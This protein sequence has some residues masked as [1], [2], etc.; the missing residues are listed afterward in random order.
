[1]DSWFFDDFHF[2][3]QGIFQ[4]HEKTTRKKRRRVRSGFNKQVQ[5]AIK[6]SVA[7]RKGTEDLD[8]RD[9]VTPGDR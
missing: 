5:V 3:S 6:P 9:A 7:A 1:M 4:I 2:T 8:A